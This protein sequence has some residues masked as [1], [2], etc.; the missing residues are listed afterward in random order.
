M[1]PVTQQPPVPEP[2]KAHGGPDDSQVPVIP[3]ASFA[4]GWRV[5]HRGEI[6]VIVSPAGDEYRRVAAHEPANLIVTG[7]HESPTRLGLVKEVGTAAGKPPRKRTSRKPKMTAAVAPRTQKTA[8]RSKPA[9]K[10]ATPAKARKPRAVAMKE[11]TDEQIVAH[12]RKL[13]KEHGGVTVYG[14]CRYLRLAGLGVGYGRFE[15]ILRATKG[16]TIRKG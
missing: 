15:R 2:Q 10:A 5:K 6:E 16:V 3:S 13:Q 11:A 12:I 8:K 9:A 1:E 14:G 4:D 7:K